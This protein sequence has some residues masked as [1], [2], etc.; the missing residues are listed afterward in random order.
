MLSNQERGRSRIQSDSSAQYRHSRSPPPRS[1]PVPSDINS[2]VPYR[3]DKIIF[4]PY[5]PNERPVPSATRFQRS[6]S[7]GLE[8]RAAR[9]A[10]SSDVSNVKADQ[11]TLAK[12]LNGV[13]GGV[14]GV[15]K[16]CGIGKS[17]NFGGKRRSKKS[18]KRSKKSV[19]RSKKSAKRSKKS[20]TRRRK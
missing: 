4:T 8:R 11:S 17:H 3:T 14:Q 19:K 5:R 1:S 2:L 7:P 6:R 10:L 12:I 18:A 9:A 20:A 16:K 15:L 13:V